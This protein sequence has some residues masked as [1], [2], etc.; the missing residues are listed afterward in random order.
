[1]WARTQAF[2]QERDAWAASRITSQQGKRVRADTDLA[3][4]MARWELRAGQYMRSAHG[5]PKQV[6]RPD[7]ALERTVAALLDA[8]APALAAAF[9]AELAPVMAAAWSAWP[10]RSGVSKS[11]LNLGFDQ[12]GPLFVARLESLAPYTRFI[13]G[14]P[15][16]RF[17]RKPG[18]DAGRR[19][20]GVAMAKVATT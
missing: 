7:P 18:I 1:M 16:F 10:V 2:W 4:Q 5:A 6:V 12:D 15:A 19:A 17:I 13:R 20:V 8:T 3:R 11:L 14:G 9:D